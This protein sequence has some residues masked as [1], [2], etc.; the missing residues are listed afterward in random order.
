M[1]LLSKSIEGEKEINNCRCEKCDKTFEKK[2][3]RD[4]G[5]SNTETAFC[6]KCVD[7]FKKW[8]KDNGYLEKDC[9]C[10]HIEEFI[11]GT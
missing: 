10:K 6:S 8:L 7:K 9:W 4:E 5:L 1:T 3:E 2:V 11:S